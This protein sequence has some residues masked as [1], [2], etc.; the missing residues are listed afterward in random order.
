M[1]YR[2]K[3]LWQ[4]LA[5]PLVLLLTGLVLLAGDYVG[6]LS[7]DRVQNLWPVAFILTGLVELVPIESRERK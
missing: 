3:V 1:D 6:V 2:S 4:D 7:L 5:L